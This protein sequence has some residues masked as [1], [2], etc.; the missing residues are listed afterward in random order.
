M[1]KSM[2][3]ERVAGAVSAFA[4]SAT[5]PICASSTCGGSFPTETDD[6]QTAKARRHVDRAGHA[7][8]RGTATLARRGL[9]DP[10]DREAAEAGAQNRSPAARARTGAHAA[11][12]RA[13]PVTARRLR[14][15][16]PPPA[17]RHARAHGA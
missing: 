14:S 15:R 17:R 3:D 10:R 7:T 9:V 1:S 2:T 6:G 12:E 5:S 11:A 13:A 4:A 16:D 8:L